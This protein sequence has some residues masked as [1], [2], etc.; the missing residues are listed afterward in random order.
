[1]AQEAALPRGFYSQLQ[2]MI[3]QS[4]ARY[5]KSGP[6]RNAMISGGAGLRI[7]DGGR[8][9]MVAPDGT[10]LFYVGPLG[11]ALPD[12]TPQQ[13]MQI[14]RAD[15]TTVFE[16]FDA[17]V[18]DGVLRQAGNW[19]DRSGNVVI[20]DDTDSGQGHGA[21]LISCVRGVA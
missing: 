11:P 15:G 10:V 1:M 4:I 2:K 16:V 20:A 9:A 18:T 17:F 7:V 19:R 13:G 21:C 8:F 5:A 3:D 6:L 14:R 12:G